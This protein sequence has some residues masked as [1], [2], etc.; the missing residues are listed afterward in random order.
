MTKAAR[1]SRRT[2]RGPI[3]PRWVLLAAALICVVTVHA[4]AVVLPF[5]DAYIIFRYV[6]NFL[7]GEGAVYNPGERVFGISSPLFA[8]WLAAL[9]GI[10]PVFELPALAAWGNALLLAVC[11]ILVCLLSGRLG[12]GPLLAEAVAAA[13]VLSEGIL[14][15]SIG[16]MEA[17]LYLALMT[18]C[19]L[20]LVERRHTL[21]VLAASLAC[22]ARPEGALLVLIAVAAVF[23]DRERTRREALKVVMVGLIPIVLWVVAAAWYYGTPIPHSI[24]AKARPLY[25]LIPGTAFQ[26]IIL[27]SG[28]WALD[29]VHILGLALDGHGGADAALKRPIGIKVLGWTGTVVLL[30]VFVKWLRPVQWREGVRF[31]ALPVYFLALTAGYSI[32]NPLLLLWYFPLIQAPLL[33]LSLVPGPQPLRGKPWRWAGGVV[34]ALLLTTAVVTFVAHLL[35]SHW[36]LLRYGGDNAARKLQMESFERAAQW[37]GENSLEDQTVAAPEI[38]I[39]GYRLD[40]RILDSCGLISPEAIPFIPTPASERGSEIVVMPR[41]FVQAIRPDFIVS[42]P[43]FIAPNLTADAWFGAEYTKVH[44]IPCIPHN[45]RFRGVM[46]Y[47]RGNGAAGS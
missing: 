43:P 2:V 45:P 9:R 1:L 24:V 42:L 7:E 35:P 33:I 13:V 39:L 34:S 12:A 5:D 28:R 41:G 27:R 6:D 17:P 18:G 32:S 37:V 15:V 22:L 23:L 11:G 19:L 4:F 20:A 25:P 14:R 29:G 26:E 38:G 44:E 8:L 40:R 3:L 21:A 16:G 10:L 46:I 31:L 30:L 47:K 36:S